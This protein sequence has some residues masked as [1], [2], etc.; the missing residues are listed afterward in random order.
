MAARGQNYRFAVGQPSPHGRRRAWRDV[1]AAERHYHHTIVLGAGKVQ[2]TTVVTYHDGN[3]RNS[4]R[5]PSNL[6]QRATGAPGALVNALQDALSP[7]GVNLTSDG[8]WTPDKVLALI[9]ADRA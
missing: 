7:F 5:Q 8:P 2:Q 1:S 6:E 3:Q 4:S 9:P